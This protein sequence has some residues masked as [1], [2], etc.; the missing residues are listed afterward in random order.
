MSQ[1]KLIAQDRLA[2]QFLQRPAAIISLRDHPHIIDEVGTDQRRGVRTRGPQPIFAAQE[3]RQPGIIGEADVHSRPEWNRSAARNLTGGHLALERAVRPH[4]RGPDARDRSG[5]VPLDARRSSGPGSLAG[6]RRKPRRL[7]G[8]QQRR[9]TERERRN[10]DRRKP[11]KFKCGPHGGG[12]LSAIGHG[13][14][15][16]QVMNWNGFLA[17]CGHGE[18]ASR[19]QNMPVVPVPVKSRC[20]DSI[21]FFQIFFGDCQG[22]RFC[23]AEGLGPRT[24]LFPVCIPRPGSPPESADTC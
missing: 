13:T 17:D 23:Q 7:L 10:Q 3:R 2:S 14:E 15:A 6:A 5:P 8:H 24:N 4:A 11:W 1:Q 20:P 12:S 21:D 19:T 22:G 16:D 9:Q 18:S